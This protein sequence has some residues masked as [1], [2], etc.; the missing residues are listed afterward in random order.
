[1]ASEAS[2]LDV[3]RERWPEIAAL[4]EAAPAGEAE[5]IE[6]PRGARTV[7]AGGVLLGSAYDPVGEGERIAEEMLREPADLIVAVGY[8]LGHHLDAIRRRQRCPILVHEPSPARLRAALEARGDAG[9]LRESDVELCLDPEEIGRVLRRYYQTG[10]RLRVLV[11]PAMRR[12]A[13][14]E[15]RLVVDRIARQKDTLDITVSTLVTMMERWAYLTVENV[16]HLVRTPG[17]SRIA[18]RFPG[19][20]AVVCAAGPS[21]DRQLPAIRRERHRLLVI[22][23][24]QTLSALRRAG[25]EPDVVHV[26]ESANVVH[27]L[28]KAGDPSNVVLVVTPS[29]HEG[30]FHVPVRARFIAYPTPNPV[31]AWIAGVLGEQGFLQGAGT[32]AQS[33]VYLAAALGAANVLLVGQDLA[34]TNGRV[35]ASGSSYGT[36]G[37][38]ITA[39]GE[40]VY[41]NLKDKAEL[42]GLAPGGPEPVREEVVWV[43]GWSGGERVPT[44]VPYATFIEDYRDV[45]AEMRNLGVSLVNCTEG[46]ARLPEL[47]HAPFEQMLREIPEVPVRAAETLHA[48]HDSAERGGREAFVP[49]LARARRELDRM[50]ARAKQGLGSVKRA[51]RALSQSRRPGEQTQRLRDIVREQ[52]RTK[53]GLEALPWLDALVQPEVHHLGAVFGVAERAEP[54]PEQAVEE[55]KF[56][57]EATRR[58]V[59]RARALLHRLE[60]RLDET[61]SESDEKGEGPDAVRAGG[62]TKA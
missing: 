17:L 49:A 43:E 35:Y 18:G 8:A 33:A 23:I 15:S 22:A 11:H 10:T 57:F 31:G 12:L 58:G 32:V 45:S 36:M 37:Y 39:A 54:T 29:V 7:R 62:R 16:P 1:M 59:L 60:E 38:E 52:R 13:V 9:V 56:L 50:E 53:Q 3:V 2:A 40:L 61:G 21:L 28:E 42:F 30:L 47:R 41:S 46:G 44:S 34:F 14:A 51:E 25:I 24:G 27:Q 20:T 55:S 6:G 26:L 4:L 5:V 19:A 48:A